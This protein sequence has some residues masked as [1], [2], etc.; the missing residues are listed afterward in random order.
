MVPCPS[1]FQKEDT[2]QSDQADHLR[3]PVLFQKEKIGSR[4]KKPVPTK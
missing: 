1:L 4:K 3:Q 2:P